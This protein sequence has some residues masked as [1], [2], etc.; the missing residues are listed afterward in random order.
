MAQ[1]SDRGCV[2]MGPAGNRRQRLA[3]RFAG[4]R[5]GTVAIVFALAVPVVVGAAG[6]GVETA[7]WH[8]EK[9]K[10]QE[11]ADVAAHV[12]AIERRAGA[13]ISQMKT[14]AEAAIA[15]NGYTTVSDALTLNNT[16]TAGP[17]PAAT[18]WRR[19]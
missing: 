16:P 14:E 12:G 5:K 15:E 7:Y 1:I 3:E 19:S 9:L 17:S 10:V 11:M 6:F 2:L 4:D 18:R 8:Y 13:S